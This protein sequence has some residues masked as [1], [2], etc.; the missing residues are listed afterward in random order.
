MI[1][2]RWFWL[3]KVPQDSSWSWRKL[4]KLRELAKHFLNFQVGNGSSISLW[5]EA[6]Y[7]DGILF[8]KYRFRVI[9]DSSKIDAKFSSVIKDGNWNWLPARL[10]S[11]LSFKAD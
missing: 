5:L 6:W 1:E 7:P 3:L 4:L 9:Y 10:K 8:D 2:G 11:W